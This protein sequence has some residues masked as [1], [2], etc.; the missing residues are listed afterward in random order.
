MRRERSYKPLRRYII[1]RLLLVL[2]PFFLLAVFLQY[3]E[4][5]KFVSQE[6][7]QLRMHT[8]QSI[9]TSMRM[10]LSGYDMLER[11]LDDEMR[12][13]F[14]LV[15]RAYEE[16]D[17]DPM[18]MDLAEIKAD[19]RDRMDLF[20]IDREDVVVLVVDSVDREDEN[21]RD[22]LVDKARSIPVL[23]AL[24]LFPFLVLLS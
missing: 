6:A 1:A 20:V 19:L 17:G 11:L 3:V 9:S 23:F 13:A 22:R 2:T 14:P 7:D 5:H 21:H 8:E 12:A 16:A 18:K 15:V 4:T 24:L 10:I